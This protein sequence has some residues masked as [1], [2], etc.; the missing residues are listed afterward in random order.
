MKIVLTIFVL[1]LAAQCIPGC[2]LSCEVEETKSLEEIKIGNRRW[3]PEARIKAKVNHLD[4]RQS[5]LLKLL[6][7]STRVI[8]KES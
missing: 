8:A 3:P 7:A 6:A 4:R 2:M 1:L 5:R